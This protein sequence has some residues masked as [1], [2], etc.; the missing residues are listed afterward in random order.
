MKS[1]KLGRS[2]LAKADWQLL[3]LLLLALEVDE[4]FKLILVLGNFFFCATEEVRGAAWGT[5]K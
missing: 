4:G 3:T 1:W 2:K 5:E